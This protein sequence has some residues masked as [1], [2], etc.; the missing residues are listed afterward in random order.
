MVTTLTEIIEE[1]LRKGYNSHWILYKCRADKI[2]LKLYDFYCI[3]RALKF[4]PQWVNHAVKEFADLLITNE[5]VKIPNFYFKEATKT[6]RDLKRVF[7]EWK[8][9]LYFENKREF[10]KMQLQYFKELQ[11]LGEK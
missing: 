3:A 4:K 8:K 9:K 11:K 7:I 6:K 5:V 2:K 1:A 10:K